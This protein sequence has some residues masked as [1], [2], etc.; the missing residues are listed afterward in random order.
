MVNLIWV[1]VFL[2]TVGCHNPS[3]CLLC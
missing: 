2:A 3:T 1:F